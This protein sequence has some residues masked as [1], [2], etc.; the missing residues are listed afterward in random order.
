MRIDALLTDDAV[1]AEL[2]RRLARARLARNLT[3]P[4]LAAEAGVSERTLARIEAG[5]STTL[6]NLVRVLRPLGL[7]ESLDALV[8]ADTVNPFTEL[9]QRGRVRQ[10]ASRTAKRGE[11]PARE[12]RWVWGDE[13]D[14]PA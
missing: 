9:S 14:G 2:G 8:P 13:R 7:L 1:L 3:R 12:G 11:A 5:E 10:R 6:T 4:V